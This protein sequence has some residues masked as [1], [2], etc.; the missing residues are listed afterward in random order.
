MT[1][2]KK[3]RPTQGTIEKRG[4]AQW[5][6]RITVGGERR[7]KTFADK[8][9]AESWIRDLRQAALR[10]QLPKLLKA[11]SM[12]LTEALNRYKENEC[13]PKSVKS[14]KCAIARLAETESS[15]MAMA[16]WDIDES[17]IDALIQRRLAQG[18]MPAT[19]N[20][21][22]TY[23]RRAF[24]L[25]RTTWGCAKLHNPASKMKLSVNDPSVRRFRPGEEDA[26]LQAAQSCELGPR[27]V[28]RI[29]ALIRFLETT[30]SP[31][32]S[33]TTG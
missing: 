14:V 19:I 23:I 13:P 28:V 15:L 27:A 4:E 8:A 25:A 31:I 7:S 26:L 22:L 29:S 3:G 10:G 1:L 18:V 20:H 11:Q 21:D 33:C 2:S 9:S 12:T 32:K 24:V 6:A 5:R 30:R 16:L 17:D